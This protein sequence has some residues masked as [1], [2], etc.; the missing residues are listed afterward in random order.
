MQKRLFWW[1]CWRSWTWRWEWVQWERSLNKNEKVFTVIKFPI[2][3]WFIPL[4]TRC[5]CWLFKV[6]EATVA[7]DGQF[8]MQSFWRPW[9]KIVR[10][11]HRQAKATFLATLTG[12]TFFWYSTNWLN[13]CQVLKKRSFF[14]EEHSLS[15]PHSKAPLFQ[16]SDSCKSHLHQTLVF[17]CWEAGN[18]FSALTTSRVW[19][20][21]CVS[22]LWHS[23]ATTK[24]SS[25]HL[26]QW[27]YTLR[28]NHMAFAKSLCRLFHLL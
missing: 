6:V 13:C 17:S 3:F 21:G 12:F 15:L 10:W 18:S 4:K 19:I 28:A 22:D 23:A 2:F 8:L 9:R 27:Q 26:V 11:K 1:S 7:D 20:P 16:M 25:C 5:M 14:S 24:T